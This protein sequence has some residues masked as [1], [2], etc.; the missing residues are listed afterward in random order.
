ML[1]RVADCSHVLALAKS[2]GWIHPMKI[3]VGRVG[4]G[5]GW[6]TKLDIILVSFSKTGHAFFPKTGR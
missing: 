6:Q 5:V 4:R 2:E 3:H 1:Q